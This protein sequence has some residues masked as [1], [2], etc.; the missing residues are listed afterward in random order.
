M[1]C[2]VWGSHG[3]N[4]ACAPASPSFGLGVFGPVCVCPPQAGAP[5]HWCLGAVVF[6]RRCAGRAS[7]VFSDH[8]HWFSVCRVEPVSRARLPLNV[9]SLVSHTQRLALEGFC[10]VFNVVCV[11][12]ETRFFNSLTLCLVPSLF[13]LWVHQC[14]APVYRPLPSKQKFW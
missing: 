11:D 4:S 7:F 13:L 5:D 10:F 6:S 2:W 9:L 1:L 14:L 8:G 12:V 3:P